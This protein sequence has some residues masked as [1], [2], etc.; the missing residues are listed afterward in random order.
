MGAVYDAVG[1]RSTLPEIE[2]GALYYLFDEDGQC[3][4]L[5]KPCVALPTSLA[6]IRLAMFGDSITWGRDSGQKGVI[7]TEHTFANTL[8]K[9]LGISATNFGV[10]S[11]GWLVAAGNPKY[12]AY[13][14]VTATDILEY[15]CFT[16]SWGG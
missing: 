16:L 12:T 13:E 6:G 7:Q 11:Q 15:N 10:G 14:Q 1:K 3:K 2:E 5:I 9:N 4:C 8:K